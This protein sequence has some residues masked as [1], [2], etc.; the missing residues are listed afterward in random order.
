MTALTVSQK[1]AAAA[2]A[3]TTNNNQSKVYPGWHD[4]VAGAVAGA[5]ARMLTHPLD[6][7]RIRRQLAAFYK[8]PNSTTKKPTVSLWRDMVQVVQN[9]GG[10]RGLFRG[11]M[12]AIN[13]WVSYTAVQF[14]S[15]AYTQKYFQTVFPDESQRSLVAFCAGASA[16]VT[17]TL[18]SYPLDLTRTIFAARG[19]NVELE[20]SIAAAGERQPSSATAAKAK[21]PHHQFRPP[22]STVEFAT[23]L[24]K[25][26]GWKGFFAGCSPTVIQIIPYMGCSFAIYDY[27]TYGDRGVGLSAYAGSIAGA[28][29]KTLVYPMDTVKKRLQAQSFFG[30]HDAHQGHLQRRYYTGI[31]D[32]VSTIYKQE[33]P[34]AFYNGL[35]PSVIKTALAAGLSFAFFRSTKNLLES[36]HDDP[37]SHKDPPTRQSLHRRMT[38]R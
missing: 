15:Y 38:G 31:L 11:N 9:E 4:F 22:K 28:V 36:I 26:R 1:E 32:C 33:G 29:S 19:A 25:Q 34:W 21:Q 20:T 12:A 27:L 24:Y 16:G 37:F 10:I 17:A 14:S 30:A 3:K 2:A 35:V 13:L 18:S 5:G 7:V 23:N 6:L 8:D